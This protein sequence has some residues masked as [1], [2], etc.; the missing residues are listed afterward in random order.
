MCFTGAQLHW[1][2]PG[3]QSAQS[4]EAESWSHVVK[5][6]AHVSS[7]EFSPVVMSWYTGFAP[8]AS[9]DTSS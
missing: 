8:Y 7:A 1:Q 5:N 3:K 2:P 6:E 9:I 4:L